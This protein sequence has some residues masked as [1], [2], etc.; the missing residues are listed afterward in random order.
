MFF[1]EKCVFTHMA[2]IYANLLEQKKELRVQLPKD[3]FGTPIWPP[4]RHVKTLYYALTRSHSYVMNG[5][6]NL[7][8][9]YLTFMCMIPLLFNTV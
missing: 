4:W 3:L 1:L 5:W 7:V 8:F 9:S 6:R 2:S